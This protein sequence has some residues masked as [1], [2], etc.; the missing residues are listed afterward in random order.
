MSLYL[1]MKHKEHSVEIREKGYD[2]YITSTISFYPNVSEDEFYKK[3][4][5]HDI[6]NQ[7]KYELTRQGFWLSSDN[8]Y[9]HIRT[10]AIKDRVAVFCEDIRSDIVFKK[11]KSLFIENK[12]TIDTIY[13][14]N[15]YDFME[16]DDDRFLYNQN[17][18]SIISNETL[19][20]ESEQELGLYQTVATGRKF[21]THI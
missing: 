9:N 2:N 4:T 14:S 21:V 6:D 16:S 1:D 5:Y 7:I 18:N 19:V 13:L 12:I 3:F 10:L 15:V 8:S 17:I 20:I 11:L